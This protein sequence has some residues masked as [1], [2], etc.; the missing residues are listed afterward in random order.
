MSVPGHRR[1]S[2]REQPIPFL[3]PLE[4]FMYQSIPSLNISQG[5]PPGLAHSSC[6]RGR[7][8]YPLSCPGVSNQSE[9]SIILKKS[10]IFVLSLKQLSSSSFHIFIYARSEQCNLRPHLHYNKYT[11]Y[12]NLSM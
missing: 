6:P 8:F 7:V 9:S 11:A 12:Q 3:C 1:V 4:V 2:H 5:E 10:A